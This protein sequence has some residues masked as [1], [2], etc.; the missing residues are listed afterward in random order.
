MINSTL[1]LNASFQ[2]LVKSAFIV[3][4]ISTNGP[5]A[6]IT[7]D[8]DPTTNVNPPSTQVVD[9]APNLYR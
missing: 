2:G 4:L 9:A 3:G 1:V 8:F 7:I 5:N 6:G